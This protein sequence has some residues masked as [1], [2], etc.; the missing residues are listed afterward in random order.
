MPAAGRGVAWA[1]VVVLLLAGCRAPEP[2][3]DLPPPT[4]AAA[5]GGPAIVP[6][7]PPARD[8][9]RP[10]GDPE[11]GSPARPGWGPGVFGVVGLAAYPL[12]D[13]IAP[14]GVEY[15]P[16]FS[17]DF[18]ANLWLS[19]SQGVYA[20]ADTVFWG[21]KAAPGITNRSQGPFDFSKR[22]FDL[23]AGLA[24]N[25]ARRWEARA[26]AY[27]LNNLNRGTSV[28]APA[29]YADG[30]G[31]E[32]RYYLSD[33]YDALGTA[34]FDLARATFVGLGYY[35]TKELVD[36]QGRPFKPG[37]FARAYLTLDLAGDRAYLYAD[38]GL[39]GTHAGRPKL[40]QGD[41]GA[42]VRPFGEAP[43]WEF[44]AGARGSYDLGESDLERELYVAVRFIY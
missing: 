26:F 11:A 3:V 32:N 28:T 14:N 19:P 4:V 8:E 29:G 43:R 1:G 20:L 30:V 13:K 27:S 18:H 41:A 39:I 17:L 10:I 6:P 40:L 25:F 33:T 5:A 23:S 42:A 24:W 22:E 34:E 2:A 21:Q 9:P 15:T 12:A 16:I 44:R 35:P 37:P 31:V 38:A 7:A 36:N